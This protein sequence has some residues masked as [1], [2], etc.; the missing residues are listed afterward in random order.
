MEHSS[1]EKTFTKEELIA[2]E[3]LDKKESDSKLR[4]YSGPL[5]TVITALFLIWSVFQV[6]ANTIGI[7]DAMSLRTWHLFFLMLFTFLLFPTYPSENRK[8]TL[9]PVWDIVLLGV[10]IFT[11]WYL[12]KNY[13]V[14]A[15]RG[16]YLINAD[17]WL[18]GITMVLIFEAGRRACKNLAVLGLIF[19]LYNFLGMWIPGELGHVGFSVKRVLNHMIWGSQGIFGVGIGVS[20]TYIF[21]FVL[22]GA[23]LK[24]SGFSQFINDISLTLVGRT[25]G[26][27]AKV[28]VLAS[29][30]LGMINGSA[31]ANVATTGTITIPM[32]KKTGYKKEFAAA[33]EAVASTGGQFAP[34]I[35]G[36]VGFVMAEF[37][38]VSYTKVLLAACI[39]AFLYYLTLLFAVHFEAKRLGLSGLS[40]ENIPNALV[41]MK[42]QGHL[43]IPLVV[44]IGMLSFGYTPLFAAVVAIFAT[45]GAS[46]LRKET[47]MTWA[48]IVQATVEGAR[49]AVAVGMSCA[50]IG[51]IIGTVSLTGLGLSFGY[52]ILKVVGEGQLYLGGLMVMLM[53]IVLGMGV[54]GV[55][56]YVIVS[57]VSVPVLIQTGAIP[58]AAHMF[59]LIYACLSN[60]TPPVAMSSYVASGIADS[61]QTKTSLIA[62]K[63]GLTGFILPFFFLDNPIL[64]LGSTEG[65]PLL[66]TIRALIT[67][68]IGVIAL[69]S[70][71]QGYLL[72]KLNILER[73]VMVA[74]GLLFIE[75]GL[76][77][78]LAALML[79]GVILTFQYVQ[80]KSHKKEK[81][82]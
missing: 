32:M 17:L 2:Q 49:S 47:R 41:V 4:V 61:D 67:S 55:A 81:I 13:I 77:T 20:A 37:M 43:I 11:F 68:S 58:M 69:S 78:D 29:A 28:A 46:W 80:T 51:V 36:A 64:L 18:A 57:T 53:S 10:L 34:P 1:T 45:I 23:Y 3:L 27:P 42:K 50:I 44:L 72:G 52:I 26:G 21:L 19:L 76:V 65:V 56:A 60:I 39:P 63:L 9:P 38:G 66:I 35:M 74:A 33:V 75:T 59:C 15:K 82:A 73:L 40:K 5:G 30:L 14:V 31:I 62:V 25:A 22:F 70:G 6:Y 54:P 12:L 48:V 16:G 8:R 7:I 71:L 79:V 24:Y